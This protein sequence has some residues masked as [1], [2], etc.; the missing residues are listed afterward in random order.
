M[1]GSSAL[2]IL[3]AALLTGCPPP[4]P[5]PPGPAAASARAPAPPVVAG[6]GWATGRF[7]AYES[8]AHGFS[9]PLPE[10]PGWQIE[11]QKD[12]W[13]IAR[14]PAAKTEIVARM[15]ATDGLANRARCERRARDLRPLPE[16]EG[17]MILERRR[18]DLPDGFDT[19]LEVGLTP[20]SPGEPIEGFLLAI[21]GWSKRC[22]VLALVTRADGPQ[23]EATVGDRLALF[24][25]RSFL[26]MRFPSSLTPQVPREKPPLGP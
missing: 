18:V 23:A 12:R 24:V 4:V 6:T 15:L 7:V 2:A 8:L 25:E 20:S 9:L 17:A 22:F 1:R 16:R 19:V 11:D 13:L 10:D 21:G 14:H 26:R 5:G 3:A